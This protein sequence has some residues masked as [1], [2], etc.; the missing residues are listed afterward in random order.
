[1]KQANWFKVEGSE[2]DLHRKKFK[3]KLQEVH[4]Q[5]AICLTN[6]S[7]SAKSESFFPLDCDKMY[8]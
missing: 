2:F 4:L 6:S 1:M 5:K 3:V 7:F 8:A